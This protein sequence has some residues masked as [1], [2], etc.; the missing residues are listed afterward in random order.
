LDSS[1]FSLSGTVFDEEG[2]KVDVNLSGDVYVAEM[3]VHDVTLRNPAP[4]PND[5]V[6]IDTTVLNSGRLGSGPATL[7][8]RLSTDA[9]IDENDRQL[10]PPFDIAVPGES[11]LVQAITRRIPADAGEGT[12]HIGV[13]VSVA[14]NE[15][16]TSNQCLA[17]EEFTVNAPDLTVASLEVTD[18]RGQ[19]ADRL[20]HGEAYEITAVV[21]NSG[22]APT[23]EENDLHFY[24]VFGD[25]TQDITDKVDP[26]AAAGGE[27]TLVLP[28]A[29]PTESGVLVIGACIDPPDQHELNTSNQCAEGVT[30]LVLEPFDC[31]GEALIAQDIN[32]QLSRLDQARSPG[33][34]IPIGGPAGIEINNL[35]FRKQDGLL[36]GVQLSPTGTVQV[37]MID[38]TGTVFGLGMPAG[39]PAN[40]RFSGGDLS[41]D[42][43]KLYLNAYNQDLYTVVD[44]PS[45]TAAVPKAITGDKGAVQDWAYNPADGRLYGG[46]NYDGQLARLDPVS[47]QR[48]DFAVAPALGLPGLKAGSAFG[49][50]WFE[51]TGRLLLYQNSGMVFEI[52]LDDPAAPAPKIVAVQAAP[53][54]SR[55]DAA[56][57]MQSLVGAAKRMRAAGGG[58][59]ETITIEYRL[60]NLSDSELWNLSAEDDLEAVFGAYGTDWVLTGI[61]SQPSSFHNPAFTGQEDG[62]TQLVFPGQYLLPGESALVTVEIELLTLAGRRDDGYYCNQILVTAEAPDGTLYGD[63]S[64]RG[65]VADPNGDG[66]PNERDLTCLSVGKVLFECIEEAFAVQDEEGNLYELDT[67]G[68]MAP[69]ATLGMEVNNLGFRVTDRLLY[70]VELDS[71]GNV[72]IVQIDADGRV[73]DLGRPPLLPPDVRFVAGDVSADGTRMYLNAH[74]KPLY[75]LSLERVPVLPPVKTSTVTGLAGYV[76]DWAA[77]PTDGR[78]YGG[79]STYGYV[80]VLDPVTGERTNYGV[81]GLESSTSGFGGACFDRSGRL[82]LHRN[83]GALFRVDL[84]T[85]LT[86]VSLPPVAGSGLNDNATCSAPA[87]CRTNADCAAED[88]CAKA[89]GDCGGTGECKPRPVAP[90]GCI[91]VIVCGCDGVTYPTPCDAAAAGVSIDHYGSCP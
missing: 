65:P 57:C 49:G 91:Q 86:A 44:L 24:I 45:F 68:S 89:D 38:S 14:C 18:S 50:A 70:G 74:G 29:A 66:V 15:L 73:F 33:E 3:A 35:G 80:T 2:V 48:K 63:L 7:T 90:F 8:V 4:R 85:S 9:V 53:T 30:V 16:D 52:D 42:G 61:S 54:S 69:M 76:F 28:R 23:T 6:T 40:V 43:S 25:Q 62:D 36:Y 75:E 60:E 10:G 81:E 11:S 21:K 88:Y 87:R 13:C 20:R 59:P 78:L 41:D 37:V 47:G 84:S 19:V 46:D 26:L 55:N 51:A 64:T 58:L 12:F 39:L 67:G 5:E 27:Q 1:S 71:S 17:S 56:A 32:A 83:D 34:Q 79:N 77:H 22:A 82:I 72:Q 31:T